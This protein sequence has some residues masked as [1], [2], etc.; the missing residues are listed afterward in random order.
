MAMLVRND[1][2]ASLVRT[3]TDEECRQVFLAH[4]RA[5]QDATKL[6]QGAFARACCFPVGMVRD[7]AQ[8]R[9]QPDAGSVTLLLMI[10]VDPRG[11]EPIITKSR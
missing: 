7:R 1:R 2:V 5:V 9:R 6:T 4:V 3:D 10:K 11:V 8:K